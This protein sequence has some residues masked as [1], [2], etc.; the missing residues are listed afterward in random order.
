M[1]GRPLTLTVD[2]ARNASG[3]WIGSLIVPELNMK[4]APLADISADAGHVAFATKGSGESNTGQIAFHGKIE[5]A[6]VM[7]RRIFGRAETPRNS[8]WKKPAPRR[9][10]FH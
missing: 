8:N 3:A 2:L 1:P 9:W 4:G 7:R 10:I 5:S 6:T